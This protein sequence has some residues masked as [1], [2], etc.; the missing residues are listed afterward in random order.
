MKFNNDNNFSS[1]VN[2]LNAITMNLQL[3]IR[4]SY[5][6]IHEA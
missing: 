5:I 4:F 3:Y 2:Q 1:Y 6:Y